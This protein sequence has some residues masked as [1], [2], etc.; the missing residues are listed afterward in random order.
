MNQLLNITGTNTMSSLEIAELTNTA[1]GDVLK[2]IDNLLET[3][4]EIGQGNFTLTSYTDK[5]NRQSRCYEMNKTGSLVMIASYNVNF[6]TAVVNRWQEL[7]TKKP[8]SQIDILI[9]SAQLLKA[10]ELRLLNVEHKITELQAKNL[11]SPDLFT[12]AGYA[13][14]TGVSVNL[15][16]AVQLGK[17]ATT[18]CN[19]RNLMTDKMKDPRFGM[20]KMY[21]TP[22][23]EEVFLE[24]K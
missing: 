2:K 24:Y 20:V 13:S 16:L 17:K 21:P 22:V 9:E 23:L 12:I 10:Q 4:D 11:T 1:H 8:A 15:K 5:S 19:E 18:I 3:M 6:L 7:E 14:L